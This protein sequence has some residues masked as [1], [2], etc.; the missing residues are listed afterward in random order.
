MNASSNNNIF[1]TG[2]L[3]AHLINQSVFVQD[4]YFLHLSNSNN[5]KNTKEASRCQKKRANAV[6][7]R[8][9][10]SKRRVRREK[11]KEYETARCKGKYMK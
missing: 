11:K 10:Y 8:K 3:L 1:Y 2:P 6:T 4:L 5:G 9:N 7:K